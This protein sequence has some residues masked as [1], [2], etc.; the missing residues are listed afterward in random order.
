[1]GGIRMVP[2]MTGTWIMKQCWKGMSYF[3]EIPMTLETDGTG[4][5][6]TY[7]FSWAQFEEKIFLWLSLDKDT[8]SSLYVGEVVEYSMAGTMYAVTG[9]LK[10]QKGCWSAIYSTPNKGDMVSDMAGLKKS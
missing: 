1:M 3:V 9:P 5:S 8:I 6:D 10:G 7:T 4:T 2:V